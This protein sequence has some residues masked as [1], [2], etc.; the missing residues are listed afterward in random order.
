MYPPGGKKSIR[1]MRADRFLLLTLAVG[2][3]LVSSCSKKE[4]FSTEPLSDYLPLKS[5]QY[6]TYRLDSTVFPSFGT[7]SEV[8]SYREKKVVDTII[9]D[10]LGRPSYRIFRYL[11]DTA[12]NAPWTPSGTYLV[13]PTANSMEVIENNLREVKL[14]QP[15]RQDVTWKGNRYLPDA[16]YEAQFSFSNDLDIADWDYTYAAVNDTMMLNGHVINNVLTVN[17]MDRAVNAPVVNQSGIGYRDYLQERYAKGIGLV[18]QQFIMWEYQPPH[19]NVPVG[20]TN[21][22]GVTRTMIDHN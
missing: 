5:G 3:L 18:Y 7:I 16:P 1:L 21:G 11:S 15:I 13:T 2:A 17:S 14:I 12:A 6:I 22:F 10:A 20:Q 9:A 8:H 4:D 19:Q